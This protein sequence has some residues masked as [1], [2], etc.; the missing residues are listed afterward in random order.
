MTDRKLKTY[1]IVMTVLFVLAAGAFGWSIV[2]GSSS[3]PAAHNGGSGESGMSSAAADKNRA[4]I[5]WNTTMKQLDYDADI[6]FFGDSLTSRSDFRPF[7]PDKK[8]VTLG[9]PGDTLWAMQARVEAVGAVNPGQV[10]VLGGENGLKDDNVDECIAEYD[11]LLAMLKAEVPEAQIIM[12]SALPLREEMQPDMCSNDAINEFNG[13]LPALA[14]KYN[15]DYV[16]IHDLY[17]DENGE[18][19]KSFTEDGLHITSEAYDRWAGAI[20][21][22]IEN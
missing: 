14:E 1:A 22:Y 18:L 10:F 5:G 20:R 12:L 17:L 11:R 8:I 15:C 2:K 7:F 6:V 4:V 16:Y 3:G 19:D 13:R 21:P 9:C